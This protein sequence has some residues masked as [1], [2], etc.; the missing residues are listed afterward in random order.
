MDELGITDALDCFT[1]GSLGACGA[2]ALTIATSFVGGLVGKFATKYGLPWKWSKAVAL[3][4]RVWGLLKK[5]KNGFTDW[6][7]EGKKADRL[8]E[9]AEAA[10]SCATN[11]FTPK[12]KVLMAD[13]STKSIQDVDIGDKVLATD[14][15]TGKATART[16]T[17]EIKGKGTKHLVKV[18]VDTDGKKGAAT[19]SVTATDGPPFWVSELHAWIDA[20]DLHPGQWLRT[21]T[22]TYVQIAAVKRWTQHASVR[23]LTV[24]DLHTYYVVAGT[25][26]VLVHNARAGNLCPHPD[27]EGPHTTFRRDGTT[28]EIDHYETYDRPSDPRNP[29]PWVPTKR[30]DVKGKPHFDKKTKTL[31]PT[32][33]VNFPD[34][35]ARA[36]EPWE[37]P[38]RNP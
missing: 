25:L 15:K 17:A 26:P 6:L 37:I 8:E 7:D 2:T 24:A 5:I 38:R 29:H 19:A 31:I 21:S 35:S 36:A 20:T 16:V 4:K 34:N 12:T 11:S 32:P 10:T 28:G 9:A 23:N 3:G 14:P 27:A 1:T 33:H 22:G 13:G 18:T 30:V